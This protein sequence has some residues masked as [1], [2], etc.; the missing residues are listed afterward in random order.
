MMTRTQSGRRGEGVVVL[1]NEWVSE[2]I[3]LQ[4]GAVRTKE[5]AGVHFL[6]ALAGVCSLWRWQQTCA[7]KGALL[8][9]GSGQG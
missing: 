6:P 5:P 1:A 7:G 8:G 9:A 4:Q 3:I 2:R